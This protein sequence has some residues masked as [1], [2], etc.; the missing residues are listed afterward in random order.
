VEND[1]DVVKNDR[2][3]PSGG[4]GMGILRI[5]LL[6]GSAAVALA[7]ILAPIADQQVRNYAADRAPFGLDDMATGSIKGSGGNAGR[8]Y[9]IH[10]SVL[11]TSPDAV[12]V[13][14]TDGRRAGDC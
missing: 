7:L 4:A 11:Q 10:K 8:V 9:T 2:G 1:W 3:W 5:T 13:I 6:F 14:H 12:C